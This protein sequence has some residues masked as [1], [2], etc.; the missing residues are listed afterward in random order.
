MSIEEVERRLKAVT[1]RDAQ[2]QRAEV[3][4]ASK[5]DPWERV[6][7]EMREMH[8]EMREI[9]TNLGRRMDTLEAR[10]TALEHTHGNF[11]VGDFIAP[12]DDVTAAPE[13]APLDW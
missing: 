2:R 4:A 3:A 12:D 1:I 11:D 13:D 10:M 6:L 8:L 9:G 7:T 5:A